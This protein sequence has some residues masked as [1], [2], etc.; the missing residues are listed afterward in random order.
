MA[1]EDAQE[2]PESPGDSPYA[3]LKDGMLSVLSLLCLFID[4][5]KTCSESLFKALPEELE[6][7]AL[8]SHEGDLLIVILDNLKHSFGACS[9]GS[10]SLVL[11][12]GLLVTEGEKLPFRRQILLLEP[13]GKSIIPE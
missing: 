9:Y 12:L 2:S 4:D 10:E 11:C 8:V 3:L 13:L 7:V 5:T 1:S 6:V